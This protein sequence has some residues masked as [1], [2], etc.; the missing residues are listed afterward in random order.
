ML[1]QPFLF[2]DGVLQGIFVDGLAVRIADEGHEFHEHAFL[3][4]AQFLAE[5]L[6]G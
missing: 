2:Q 1:C 6:A 5:I 3:A 4:H